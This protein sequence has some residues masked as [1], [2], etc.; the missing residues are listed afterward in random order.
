MTMSLLAVLAV[1]FLFYAIFYYVVAD[2]AFI[3]FRVARNIVNGYGIVWNPGGERIDVCTS[4][5]GLLL[6]TIP[7]YFNIDPLLYSRILYTFLTLLSAIMAAYMVKITINSY[8][9]SVWCFAAILLPAPSVIQAIHGMDTPLYIFMLMLLL[10]LFHIN[11]NLW[12][13]YSISFFVVLTRPEGIVLVFYLFYFHIKSNKISN[14]IHIPFMAFLFPLLLFILFQK[15]YFGSPL[16]S[17]FYF[18][19]HKEDFI[20]ARYFQCLFL[21]LNQ[22]AMPFFLLTFLQILWDRKSLPRLFWLSTGFFILGSISYIFFDLRMNIYHRFFMHYYPFIVISSAISF[23]TLIYDKY[24]EKRYFVFLLSIMLLL[25]TIRTS[26]MPCWLQYRDY[27]W[28]IHNVLIPSGKILNKYSE[29]KFKLITHFAGIIPYESDWNTLD[30]LGLVSR[31]TNDYRFKSGKY[32]IIGDEI[33]I[34]LFYDFNPDVAIFQYSADWM[35]ITKDN[36][37]HQFDI[38]N[39]TPL[40]LNGKCVFVVKKDNKIYDELKEDLKS[41]AVSDLDTSEFNNIAKIG[42]ALLGDK[43][44]S[45]IMLALSGLIN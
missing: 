35:T 28:G 9:I 15:T 38:V 34:D 36:R 45:K 43:L 1:F 40:T 23:K 17:S 42:K 2:D 10:Y 14:N 20:N 22:V 26:F 30:L 19:F 5:L 7:F 21:F 39:I 3:T 25:A 29:Y 16:P 13:F 18:K 24:F 33:T 4:K 31:E 37:F 41:I 44:Y 6:S 11:A 32:N 27:A 12:I 8:W